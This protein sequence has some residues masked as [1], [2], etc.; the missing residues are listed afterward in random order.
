MITV[1]EY[2]KQSKKLQ[3]HRNVDWRTFES[4][5][6]AIYWWDLDHST[7]DEN[8]VLSERFHFHPLAIQ[9]CIAELH[10]PKIDFYETYLYLVI[11]GVDVDR[12]AAEGFVPK[13]LDVFLGQNYLVTYHTKEQR[14]IN[15]VLHRAEENSPIFEY[16][17]DF[18]LYSI[19]D[20]LI[21]HYMPVLEELEDQLDSYEDRI[22]ESAEPAILRE[23]LT[24]KRTLM[25]LKKTVFPQRE[26]INHLARNEYQ[27]VNPKTQIYFRDIYDMLYRMADMTESFRDVSTAL[28]ETYLSTVSNRL[29]ETM[30][31]LTLLATIF[32][33]LTVIT[34]IYG[35][36]FQHMPEL[37]MKYGYYYVLALMVVVTAGMLGYFKLRKW[38]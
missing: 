9:D 11:H 24:V 19:L 29:N 15:E 3:I 17:L 12:T 26:V 21:G 38:L 4:N 28:V 6:E 7:E 20:I 5:P 1:V 25:R 37:Q 34:G 16:G 36:N 13:E 18:V 22:F 2:Q 14:S 32:M 27:F 30:K 33:P 10:Y 23:I 35:M 31:V 8:L